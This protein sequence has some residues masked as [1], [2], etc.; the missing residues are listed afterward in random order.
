M[1]LKLSD[2]KA[3]TKSKFPDF[4]LDAEDEIGQTLELR[5]RPAYVLNEALREEMRGVYEKFSAAK[6]ADDD[7]DSLEG[8]CRDTM[9]IAARDPYHFEVLEQY[10][11]ANTDEGDVELPMWLTIVELYREQTQLGEA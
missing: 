10:V 3:T 11:A 9:R 1:S 5:F 4:V 2:L 7:D 6:E 8:L